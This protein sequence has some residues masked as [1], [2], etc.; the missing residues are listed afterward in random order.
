MTGLAGAAIVAL[1]IL[2]TGCAARSD[3]ARPVSTPIPPPSSAPA[4]T[5]GVP[6]PVSIASSF[7]P[8]RG[9]VPATITVLRVLDHVAP[10]ASIAPATPATHWASAQVEVCPQ[11][12]VILGYPAWVLGDDSGRT[13]QVSRV[14]HPQFPQPALR[15]GITLTRCTR[16]WVTWVTPNALKPTK[17]SFEQAYDVP[18]A[19]RM[20]P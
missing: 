19:W 17:V 18:G 12:P 9:D 20:S 14:L 6:L 10:G 1:G 7:G 13:A 4:V 3:A 11:K 16:G 15:N 8:G 2:A 5:L